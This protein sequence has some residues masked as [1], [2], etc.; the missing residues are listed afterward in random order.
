M[1]A[2]LRPEYLNY[3]QA[4]CPGP[5]EAYKMSLDAATGRFTQMC[6][7]EHGA[8][9]DIPTAWEAHNALFAQPA[10]TGTTLANIIEGHIAA[11]H[12][13]PSDPSP[14]HVDYGEYD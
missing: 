14:E 3:G 4:F 11:V 12:D 10:L 1:T 8:Y 9:P 7:C 13:E 5:K 2:P 6:V